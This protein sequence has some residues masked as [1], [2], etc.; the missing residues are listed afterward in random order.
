MSGKST[1][2][3]ALS[4]MLLLGVGI[5]APTLIQAR[6]SQFPDETPY[7][8][9]H[10]FSE[11]AWS[12][13][14]DWVPIVKSAIEKL[15]DYI[16][17]MAPEGENPFENISG[18]MN[19]LD[20]AH[21]YT[22]HAYVNRFNY[23]MFYTGFINVSVENMII[24]D[25]EGF[26]ASGTI[27]MQ[28]I[29]QVYRTP[30]GQE[31]YALQTYAMTLI[32]NDTDP[33]GVDGIIDENDDVFLTIGFDAA[34]LFSDL[35]PSAQAI[36]DQFFSPGVTVETT[37]LTPV[38]NG[39]TWGMS[40]K[41]LKLLIW[42]HDV[43]ESED[44]FNVGD[45]TL[46]GVLLID[47]LSFE[48][49]LGFDT[50]N[51]QVTIN[52]NYVIGTPKQLIIQGAGGPEIINN[53]EAD[54]YNLTNLITE[55]GLKIA[56]ANFQIDAVVDTTGSELQTLSDEAQQILNTT[57]DFDVSDGSFT[58]YVGDQAILSAVFGSK[59]TYSTEHP[60][61][62]VTN[63]L[64]AQTRIYNLDRCRGLFYNPLSLIPIITINLPTAAA[65]LYSHDNIIAGVRALVGLV[66]P[67]IPSEIIGDIGSE[68]GPLGEILSTWLNIESSANYYVIS[69]P[70]WNGQ[71]IIHDP[72]FIAFADLSA[73]LSPEVLA[74]IAIVG[75]VAVV[76]VALFILR[77]RG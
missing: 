48:Y 61:G 70:E 36:I 18:M 29:L 10:N 64:I 47:E 11:E 14:V 6:P 51:N 42:G 49:T 54:N 20:N 21:L 69:Y 62:T 67:I 35:D 33:S 73:I 4:L 60:N 3:I 15:S 72:V 66:S 2:I 68:G 28:T 23:R 22:Y 55:M 63:G 76:V 46:L 1:K 52:T 19:Q 34:G 58:D 5:L 17:S 59:K 12:T 16:G 50:A 31:V 45:V 30:T 44:E 43:A 75:V 56:I 32:F 65:V 37:P 9:G 74:P 41:D 8:N 7:L 26:T 39:Y 53:T 27:P 57:T 25:Q 13:T 24:G 77:R 71:K 40:Y 38:D